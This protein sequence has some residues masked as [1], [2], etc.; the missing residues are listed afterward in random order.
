MSEESSGLNIPRT[1]WHVTSGCMV[2]IVLTMV[3]IALK[4]TSVSVEIADTK[5]QLNG[6]IND[7]AKAH[8]DLKAKQAEFDAMVV[9]SKEMEDKYNKAVALLKQKGVETPVMPIMPIEIKKNDF[10]SLDEKVSNLRMQQRELA[11]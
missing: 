9:H 7:I 3:F 4:S 1:F 2:L 10:K 8:E 11:K 6:T 5:I